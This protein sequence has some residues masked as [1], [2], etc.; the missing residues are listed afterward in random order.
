MDEDIV[1]ILRKNGYYVVEGAEETRRLIDMASKEQKNKDK[2]KMKKK[3]GKGMKEDKPN[4][5]KNPF[6]KK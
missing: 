5:K 6:G 2:E 1:D 3:K 4:G